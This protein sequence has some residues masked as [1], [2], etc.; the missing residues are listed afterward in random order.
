MRNILCFI[1]GPVVVWRIS[2]FALFSSRRRSAILTEKNLL[3]PHMQ[4]PLQ[5][6]P[7]RPELLETMSTIA[8]FEKDMRLDTEH[9]L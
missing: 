4:K 9:R 2:I 8:A 3:R 7:L 5:S 6:I 1:L